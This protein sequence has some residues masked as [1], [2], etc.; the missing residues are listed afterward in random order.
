[1]AL[2]TQQWC[3]AGCVVPYEQAVKPCPEMDMGRCRAMSAFHTY[4]KPDM[5]PSLLGV[6][7]AGVWGTSCTEMCTW[8]QK[9]K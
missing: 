3:I 5:P 4:L 8:H 6:M 2:C 1:M 7:V 9:V